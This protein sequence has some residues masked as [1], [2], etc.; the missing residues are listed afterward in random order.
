MASNAQHEDRQEQRL[1]RLRQIAEEYTEEI[2]NAE[3]REELAQKEPV[4]RYVAVTSE[5]SPDSGYVGNGNLL[6]FGSLEE[7]SDVLAGVASEGWLIHG[8][9]WDLDAD[10]SLLGNLDASYEVKIAEAPVKPLFVVEVE[11]RGDGIYLFAERAD[12]EAF[13]EAVKRNGGDC[14]IW[15]EALNEA[16]ATKILIDAEREL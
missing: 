3:A 15:E 16:R 11:G 9:I 1:Q 14:E 12:A 7:T 5:G 13:C 6:V 4:S 2:H 8:R 10:W